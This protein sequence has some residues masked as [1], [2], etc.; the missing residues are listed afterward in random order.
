MMRIYTIT[1]SPC[2]DLHVTADELILNGESIVSFDSRT[3]GGK[4]YNVSRA[5]SSAGVTS[6]AA[7]VLGSENCAEFLQDAEKNNTELIVFEY[8]GR[9][10][11][12]LTVHTK[13][14]KETRI[15]IEANITCDGVLDRIYNSITVT[16]GDIVALCGSVPEGIDKEELKE[17]L[18]SFKCEGA[19]IVIDSRSFTKEDICTVKPWL[20]KPNESEAEKYLG[21]KISSADGLG[22]CAKAFIDSGVEN[23][24]ISLGG[25]GAYLFTSEGEINLT[26]PKI[27]PVSTVGAGD[28][29][30][31][32]FILATA[33]NAEK[34]ETLRMAIAF[35]TA[36][37]LTDGTNP[38]KLEEI[39]RIYERIK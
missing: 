37:C 35:G 3:A 15:S 1:L 7:V 34:E 8:E 22:E 16:D 26:P 30:I 9:I 27:T 32:G 21:K 11:E 36:A 5:L 33:A 38:P 12:N 23:V 17:I 28:S 14:N 20:I 31:A 13:D 25:R 10:R 29:M 39:E 6:Y 24:L 19:R 2:Y 18:L 4:G